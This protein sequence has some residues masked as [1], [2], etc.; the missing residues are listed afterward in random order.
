MGCVK[1]CSSLASPP[2]TCNFISQYSLLCAAPGWQDLL[3]MQQRCHSWRELQESSLAAVLG[4]C[5]GH[6]SF[7]SDI[8]FHWL[9]KTVQVSAHVGSPLEA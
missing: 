7:I 3:S 8:P 1:S 6:V 9:L 5:K 2:E 4:V